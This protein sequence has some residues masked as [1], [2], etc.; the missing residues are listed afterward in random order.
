VPDDVKKYALVINGDHEQRHL[1]NVERSLKVLEG[2]GYETFVASPEK[3]AHPSDHYVP[4]ALDDVTKLVGLLE[5]KIDADDE[6][7]IYT[8]GHGGEEDGVGELC[9]G[10]ECDDEKIA[11]LLD[12]IEYGQRTVI[13]DQCYSGNWNNI[14]LDDPKSLFISA[15]SE[16]ETVCC[17]DIAP[18]FWAE[19][20]PD[21][22][23]DDVISWQ[24][25]Y[26]Y[27]LEQ[28]ITKSIPQFIPSPGYIQAGQQP[29]GSGVEEIAD[30]AG[31]KDQLAKVG[32][33]QYAVM[34]FSAD[35]CDACKAYQ[36]KFEKQA[37]GSGGQHLYLMTKNYD[38]AQ[39]MGV[40]PV[41]TV[42]VINSEGDRYAVI[43]KG[44]IEEEI[45]QFHLPLEELALK[46]M[47][48]AEAEDNDFAKGT[49]FIEIAS[50]LLEGGLEKEGLSAL[51]KALEAAISIEFDIVKYY[52]F[53]GHVQFLISESGVG[54]EAIPLFEKMLDLTVGME[55]EK[56]KANALSGICEILSDEGSGKKAVPLFEEIAKVV[57][58]FESVRWKIWALNHVAVAYSEINLKKK[59]LGLFDES[60]SNAESLVIVY[61]KGVQL[62][63]ISTKLLDAGFKKKA[64]AV[65]KQSLNHIESIVDPYGRAEGLGAVGFE[66]AFVGKKKKALSLF[67]K[68]LKVAKDIDD[69]K[70]KAILLKGLAYGLAYVGEKEHA[71]AVFEEAIETANEID[72]ILESMLTLGKINEEIKR[73]GLEGVV[74]AAKD[75]AHLLSP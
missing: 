46:K 50:K 61:N 53:I 29:F 74:P 66:Y 26:A 1:D 41:P 19:K 32:A 20:I 43:D 68:S 57:R 34:L 67:E 33:G 71:I 70:D 64:K 2:E 22:N 3:P 23:D 45:S 73:A 4:P 7:V 52:F 9:L 35:W 31:L 40:G 62:G 75:S 63:L 39:T 60:I 44:A 36:P 65:L 38:L 54:M 16:D 11:A 15:G 51:E 21:L 59:A 17:N 55:D 6:L 12:G 18:N 48:L 13:M 49:M 47:A 30:E 58:E 8:T 25:R 28:G 5:G 37:E 14:F 56:L 69:P 27:A 42:L 24:E 72:S 10:K